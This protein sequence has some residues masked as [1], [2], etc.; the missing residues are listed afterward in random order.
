MAETLKVY[1]ARVFSAIDVQNDK[2]LDELAE[3]RDRM[4]LGFSPVEKEKMHI[5]LQFFRDIDEE[6]IDE[7]KGAME[8]INLDPFTAEASGVGCFPSREYIRVIWAGLNQE[9]K[10]HRIYN[11]LSS[12][13]V[14][15]DNKHDFK[16]HITLM[17]V[18]DV[19][20]N[21]KRK[22]QKMVREFENHYFSELEVSK[23]KLFRSD[24]KQGGSRYRELHSYDL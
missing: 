15:S 9:E 7:L 12:H 23:V 22:L 13:T 3:V 18:K 6:D 19:G 14:A 10:F 8:K 24:L 17:R 2:L 11:Q 4:D 5:T 21:E 1:M 20:K 16:P